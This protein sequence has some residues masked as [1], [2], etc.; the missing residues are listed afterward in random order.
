[1]KVKLKENSKCLTESVELISARFDEHEANRQKKD[2]MINSLEE[3]VLRQTEKVNKLPSLVDRQEQ[4]C[5]G[6]C[7]LV[8]GIK[9]NQNE[10]IDGA[11]VN[12]IKVK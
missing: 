9:Q 4:Y 6:N 1:M 8:N 11:V 12:K 5:R 10:D 2:E 3:K 7:I